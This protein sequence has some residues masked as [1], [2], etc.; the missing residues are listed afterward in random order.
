MGQV[1]RLPYLW[2]SLLLGGFPPML[3]LRTLLPPPLFVAGGGGV[4]AFPLP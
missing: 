4:R 2:G 1:E 3:G